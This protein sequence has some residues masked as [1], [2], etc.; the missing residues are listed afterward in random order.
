MKKSIL[1]ALI[2]FA[3]FAVNA[4]K[5]NVDKPVLKPFKTTIEEYNYLTTGY[6]IQIN[7]GLDMKKGYEI[8]NIDTKTSGGRTAELKCLIRTNTPAK[9]IAAYFIIYKMNNKVQDY[10]CI[11][12]PHSDN[13]ILDKY[14]NRLY[15]TAFSSE[16]LQLISYLLSLHMQ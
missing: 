11:P 7:S 8:Y 16:K 3:C 4:Q 14:F 1:A 10:I 2:I 9:E 15:N 13:D 5:V 6:A 12:G